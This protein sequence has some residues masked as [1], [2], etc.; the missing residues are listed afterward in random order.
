VNREQRLRKAVP[1]ADDSVIGALAALPVSEV[2]I[3]LAALRQARRDERQHQTELRRQRKADD[4]AHG[5]YDE[6]DLTRRNLALIASQGKR[7]RNGNLDALEALGQLRRH[8]DAWLAQAVNG[9]RDRGY[10]DH[11]IAQVL[12]VTRQA[13]SQRYPRENYSSTTHGLHSHELYPTWKAMLQR[14]ESRSADSYRYYGGRGIR[15]C[16]EWHDVAN[17]ITWIEQNL[18]ARPEE[19]TLDRIDSDGNYEP[20]NVQWATWSEQRIN[21]SPRQEVLPPVGLAA[22]ARD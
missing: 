20:G 19:M 18:G 7:A 8:A 15:V 5:N 14:C 21:R 13:V 10:S 12:G 3:I 16:A 17:F 9:C 1:G 4:R 2:T 11:D 22:S 6:S